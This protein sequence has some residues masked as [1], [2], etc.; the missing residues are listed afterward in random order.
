MHI[1]SSL[2]LPRGVSTFTKINSE[3]TYAGLD[4]S[5]LNMGENQSHF[6]KQ[7]IERAFL[8]IKGEI[9]VECGGCK[10]NISRKS[11]FDEKP[12]VFHVCSNEEVKLISHKENT[13]VAVQGACNEKIFAPVLYT[14]DDIRS[15]YRGEGTLNETATRIVRTVFDKT[16]ADYSNMVLGEVI[17]MPGKWSSYPP[18]HHPQPE[19]YYYKFK[20]EGGFGYCELGKDVVKVH[21]NSAV[22]I[23]GNLTHPQVAAPGYAMWYL[24]VIRH[25]DDN[26]YIEPVF[27]PEH[28]W[29]NERNA[30][31][32]RAGGK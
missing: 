11:N 28:L 3:K 25:L 13:E 14:P 30:P 1:K 15:E 32:W 18:H 29:V 5:V 10:Y 9:T 26:P 27:L 31:I 19:I 23:K 4:F 16:N 22:V 2:N 7:D 24:W 12:W 21:N 6:D 20:P 8:L 17:D